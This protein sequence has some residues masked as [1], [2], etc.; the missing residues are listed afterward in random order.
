MTNAPAAHINGEPVH[1]DFLF[2]ALLSDG[3]VFEQTP[4]DQDSA[5]PKRSKF[6]E[7]LRVSEQNQIQTFWLEGRGRKYLVDLRD[8]HFEVN[9]S[10]FSI[11]KEDYLK[12][13]RI[14][15]YRSVAV[16]VNVTYDKSTG[17]MIKRE[18]AGHDI[19]YCMGWQCTVNGKN[20]Q[21]IIHVK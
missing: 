1:L 12:D 15:Y 14:I 7:L 8:G 20:Y 4:D 9:Y 3:T 17:K 19:V 2:R 21:H 16:R 6:T 5:D 10:P 18:P 13:F 11:H